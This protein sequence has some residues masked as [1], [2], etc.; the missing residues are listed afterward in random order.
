MV[1]ISWRPLEIWVC[2]AL[3][4]IAA[5][6]LSYQITRPLIDYDEAIYANRIVSTLLSG[7]VITPSMAGQPQLDKPPLY[8]WMTMPL[9]ATFG[10]QE[11]TFRLPGI[12]AAILCYLLTFLIVRHLTANIFAASAGFLLLLFAPWVYFF[13]IEARLDSGV[14]A[15]ILAALFV[16]LKGWRDERYL[17]L[18]FP[19]LAIGFLFKS[20][21][22]LLIIPVVLVYCFL[23]DEWN[24][25]KKRHL[26]SGLL[27][28]LVIFFPWHLYE[29]WQYG[30]AF[31][32]TYILD[33]LGRT[34]VI[35]T[36]THGFGDYVAPLASRMPLWFWSSIALIGVFFF[37]SNFPRS[38]VRQW[39][40]VSAPLICGLFIFLFFSAAKTH[41]GSYV[42]PAYPFLAMFFAQFLHA[43]IEAGKK[44]RAIVYILTI[45]LILTGAYYCFSIPVSD[46]QDQG[47]FVH[48]EKNIGT[49]YRENGSPT[50]PLYSLMWGGLDTINFYSG[51]ST[52]F[53]DWSGTPATTM[54]APFFLVMT[55]EVAQIFKDNLPSVFSDLEVIYMG[56]YL[57]L[58]YSVDDMR[59]GV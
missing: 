43:S 53:V 39:R 50:E 45:I 48:E 28:A 14:I 7:N 38:R 41:L 2:A 32:N 25:I 29:T 34:T 10:P 57:I 5:V 12:L 44:L 15:S 52:R 46:F 9:V 56:E 31:W 51:T 47:K 30:S 26:W 11:W 55:A 37:T 13:S 54:R 35:V 16:L 24:W 22:A 58:F 49:L 18:F 27:I 33:Q 21:I 40:Q 3:V 1:T 42:L 36:G 8:F 17:L 4:V 59:V 19:F 23:Y 20:I 6:F